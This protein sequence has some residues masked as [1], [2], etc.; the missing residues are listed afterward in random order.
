MNAFFAFTNSRNFIL[1]YPSV[2]LLHKV[3]RFGQCLRPDALLELH[4]LHAMPFGV[5]T[6]DCRLSGALFV[7]HCNIESMEESVELFLSLLSD[8]EP[9]RVYFG[10]VACRI[11]SLKSLPC[12]FNALD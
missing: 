8:I 3:Q 4:Q 12:F 2:A 6:V 1:H 11:R 10:D 7:D 5:V 9:L